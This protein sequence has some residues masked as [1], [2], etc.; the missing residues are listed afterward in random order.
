MPRSSECGRDGEAYD[1]GAREPVPLSESRDRVSLPARGRR[2]MLVSCIHPGNAYSL[3]ETGRGRIRRRNID[4]RMLPI[5]L[6]QE[7]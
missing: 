3:T 1:A 5:D 2:T 7:G 6:H 4:E